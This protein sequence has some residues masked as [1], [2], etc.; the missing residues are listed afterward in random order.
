MPEPQQLTFEGLD[1]VVSPTTDAAQGWRGPAACQIVGITY[2]QLDYWDRTGLVRPSIAGASGSGSVRLY[3]FRDLAVLRVVKGL[4]DVGISLTNIRIA[5][6]ALRDRG[7]T[8]LAGLTLVSDGVSVYE[9]TS[10]T[11]LVDL[12]AGGQGA[13][14]IAV[15]ASLP[16]L[17]ANVRDFAPETVTQA[18]VPGSGQ[19]EL[20]KRRLSRAAS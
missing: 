13:F 2:R 12:L 19:D 15:G 20:A 7:V 4:L 17:R 1:A 11:E 6:D 14:A 16:Q 18:A 10:P 3:S 8:E 5:V 9:Y